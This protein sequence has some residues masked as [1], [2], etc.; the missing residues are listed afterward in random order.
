MVMLPNGHMNRCRGSVMVKETIAFDIF[1]MTLQSQLIDDIKFE[2]EIQS[3]VNEDMRQFLESY[4]T[5]GITQ[6]TL[7]LRYDAS[8]H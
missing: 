6:K 7:Q 8:I 1:S 4:R 2:K 5:N 3:S